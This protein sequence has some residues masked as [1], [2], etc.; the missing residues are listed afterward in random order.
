MSAHSSHT[1]IQL[2]NSQAEGIRENR[3]SGTNYTGFS[4]LNRGGMGTIF[5]T[6]DLNIGREVAMKMAVNS[7]D[8]DEALKRLIHEARVTANLEHPNIVPVHEI[9]S[10]NN[11]DVYYTMKYVQ[12]DNL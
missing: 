8:T 7:D 11:N 6:T 10:D 1:I 12:G 2:P 5:R 4:V 9:N 3:N